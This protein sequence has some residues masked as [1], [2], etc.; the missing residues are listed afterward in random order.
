MSR[1]ILVVDDEPAICELVRFHL[2]R[3]GFRVLTTDNGL[4]ALMMQ[5]DHQPDLVILDEM[6]PALPGFDV[7]RRLR[8]ESQVPVIML[9]ARKEEVDRVVG[10]E[11][12]AD[13][14]VTKPFSVRELIARV[15]AI[16]RRQEPPVKTLAFSNNGITVRVE[17][18]R[19][20]VDDQPINLTAT[21]FQILALFMRHPGR[22]FS[23]SDLFA[24]VWGYDSHGDTRT[25]NVHIRNLRDKL[26]AKGML[27]ES[28]RGVGYRLNAHAQEDNA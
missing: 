28:V 20:L 11:L 18:Q 19:A 12:G 2:E 4:D 6:L 14:Y 23:R 27:I 22:V 13:D 3:D 15:R 8:A 7:L 10:L 17:E 5:Q 24:S 1:T 26:G 9:T 16:F 25:V 21:E